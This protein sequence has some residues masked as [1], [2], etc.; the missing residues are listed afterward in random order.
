AS[1]VYTVT[2]DYEPFLSVDPVYGSPGQ[3]IHVTGQRYK[4]S[5]RVR[6]T[7]SGRDVGSFTTDSNGNLDAIV[8]VPSGLT[9]G[10]KVIHACGL[11]SLGCADAD[12]VYFDGPTILLNPDT[13]G[14]G[15]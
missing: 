10:N 14:S 4:A 9:V 1:A 5:E 2:L 7:M 15:T 12:F 6:V 13:G 8:T 3:H 11:R